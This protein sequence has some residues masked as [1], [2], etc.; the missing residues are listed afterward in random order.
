V[1]QT[2]PVRQRRAGG[3]GARVA[4]A[5]LVALAAWVYLLLTEDW[6]RSVPVFCAAPFGLAVGALWVRHRR[7]PRA[8]P[9]DL[10][11]LAGREFAWPDAREPVLLAAWLIPAMAVTAPLAFVH[12]V[13][14]SIYAVLLAFVLLFGSGAWLS[15]VL[16]WWLVVLPVLFLVRWARAGRGAAAGT[17]AAG[18]LGAVLLGVVVFAVTL[19]LSTPSPGA[20]RGPRARQVLALLGVDE[21]AVRSPGLLWVARAAVLGTALA[22]VLLRRAA[23]RLPDAGKP[24]H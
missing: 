5:G 21:S 12:G 11:A 10:R 20:G 1:S 3:A 8:D 14:W 24:V 16:V 23:R 7:H 13:D 22:V 4:V 2:G 17:S 6:D 18:L 15:G 19:V 9:V